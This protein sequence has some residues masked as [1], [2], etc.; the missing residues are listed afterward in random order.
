MEDFENLFDSST[1]IELVKKLKKYNVPESAY[2]KYI[3][4]YINL[5]TREKNIL[6]S[7]TFE[8]TPYCNLNCKM[9][10]I[11]LQ[12]NQEIDKR[13]LTVVQWKKIFNQAKELGMLKATLTG[14]ECLTYEHFDELYLHLYELGVQIGVMTNAVLLNEKR[15]DFFNKYKPNMI[16]IT[17]YGSSDSTYEKVTGYRCYEKVIKNIRMAKEAG[18]NIHLSITPNH[19]MDDIMETIKVAESLEIPFS[20]NSALISP[21]KNTERRKMDTDLEDYVEI[22]KLIRGKTRDIIPLDKKITEGFGD[23]TIPVFGLKC[24]GGKNSCVINFEGK[25]LPCTSLENV[26]VDVNHKSLSDAWKEINNLAS[27]YPIPMECENCKY[28]KFCLSCV[29]LH[30]DI[31]PLGHCDKSICERTRKMIEEGIIVLDS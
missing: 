18:L 7:A 21:R 10:Y 9:C 23:S 28:K 25:V 29:A 2:G 8:I 4:S 19:Y 20:V 6:L 16:S 30:K 26:F 11:H 3:E 15:I 5:K 13:F 14:G 1:V 24:G 12:K 31:I 27:N 17:L 22:N